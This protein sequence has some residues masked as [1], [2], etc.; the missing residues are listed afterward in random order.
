MIREFALVV[1]DNR[2]KIIDRI[3]LDVVTNPSGLGFS[4]GIET[5]KTEVEEILVKAS[6]KLESINLDINYMHGSEYL[7]AKSLRYWIEKNTNKRMAIEWINAA[8]TSYADCIVTKFAFSEMQR[9]NAVTIPLTIKMLSPLF[10]VVENEITITPSIG[11]K[12]YPYTYPYSYGVGVISNNEIE[13][14]Y[15]KAIPLIITLY[16]V[17]E[18][19]QVG[20]RVKGESNLYS[21][22]V[23]ENFNLLENQ[24]VTINAVT[25]KIIFF[26]GTEEMDGYN[27]IDASKDSFIF[28]K[29]SVVSELTASVGSDKSGRLEASYRKY[30][31]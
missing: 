2:D 15:I 26:N 30:R 16:G 17:M 7:K 1:L 14:N 25:R 6:Q 11:G 27:Y 23:F 22:V 13:N 8:G 19:V 28:A 3:N 5:I 4:L 31:L 9:N 20:I 29:E 10:E 21:Q 12:E 24:Y 18:S